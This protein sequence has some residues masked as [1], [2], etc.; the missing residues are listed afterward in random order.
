MV[1]LPCCTSSIYPPPDIHCHPTFKETPLPS[2]CLSI[3]WN[4]FRG[5]RFS[6]CKKVGTGLPFFFLTH[7][8]LFHPFN[9]SFPQQTLSFRATLILSFKVLPTFFLV[10]LFP[11]MKRKQCPVSF[12]S[13]FFYF[14][15]SLALPTP[16]FSFLW[17]NPFVPHWITNKRFLLLLLLLSWAYYL[18]WGSLLSSLLLF[19]SFFLL[20]PPDHRLFFL[21][22]SFFPP[23]YLILLTFYI[24]SSLAFF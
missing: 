24:A 16:P 4:R 13:P 8:F 20:V 1:G 5:V 18:R 2:Y 9:A 6:R 14:Q 22:P 15:I 23:L 17:P 12:N 7:F 21:N 11:G 3:L 19:L 10:I